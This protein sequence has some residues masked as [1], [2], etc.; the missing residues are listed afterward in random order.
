[1]L[2][3]LCHHR[4]YDHTGRVA[5]APWR[6]VCLFVFFFFLVFCFL[7]GTLYKYLFFFRASFVCSLSV[8]CTSFACCLSLFLPHKADNLSLPLSA[9]LSLSPS[10]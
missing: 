4:L 5:L 2:C 6:R 1:M 7:P 8:A 10:L 9:S 3:I